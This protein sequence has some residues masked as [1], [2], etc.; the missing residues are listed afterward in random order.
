[1]SWWT[2]GWLA[3]LGAFVALEGPALMN[4]TQGDTLS[5]HVWKW[6]ATSRADM[7]KDNGKT[8][9]WVRVRRV[10]L[11]GFMAWLSIHFATGG[12]YV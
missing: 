7:K 6:F 10:I 9:G 8:T 1:M 4:K 2:V 5:E 12:E 11:V 3:W